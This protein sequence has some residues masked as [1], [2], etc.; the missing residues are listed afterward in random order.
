MMFLIGLLGR[1]SWPR[2]MWI[3]QKYGTSVTKEKFLW[4]AN[5]DPNS[6]VMDFMTSKENL[7]IAFG[8][9]FLERRWTV[10][11]WGAT[12]RYSTFSVQ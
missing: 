7:W 4:L 8:H 9:R 6:Q 2:R 12:K 5:C 11:I 10:V 1:T 3:D